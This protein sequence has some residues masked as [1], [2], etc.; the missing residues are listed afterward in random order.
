MSTKPLPFKLDPSVNPKLEPRRDSGD[1]QGNEILNI[2][3]NL[4]TN[5]F[6]FIFQSQENGSTMFYIILQFSIQL[7]TPLVKA[8]QTT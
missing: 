1:N 5:R 3:I 7:N 8:A 6:F 2:F 4:I